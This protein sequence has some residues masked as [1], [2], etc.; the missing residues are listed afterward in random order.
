M[1]KKRL[2]RGLAIKKEGKERQEIS[3]VRG[4]NREIETQRRKFIITEDKKIL[5][6]EKSLNDTMQ[7]MNMADGRPQSQN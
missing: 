4:Y 5:Q 6:G 7:E 2:A 3:Q 1:K